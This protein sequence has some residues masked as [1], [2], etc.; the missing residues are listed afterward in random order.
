MRIRGLSADEETRRLAFTR[1]R[2]LCDAR[3]ELGAARD[4]GL[5]ESIAK[6]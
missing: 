5:A 6:S 1:E 2:A 4:Q 3:S